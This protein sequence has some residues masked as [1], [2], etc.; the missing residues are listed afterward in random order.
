ML[1]AELNVRLH[2]LLSMF[3]NNADSVSLVK[4]LMLVTLL[5][6]TYNIMHMCSC[7]KYLMYLL[8]HFKETEVSHTWLA[9]PWHSKMYN[10]R[11]RLYWLLSSS[12]RPLSSLALLQFLITRT[13]SA[14]I[15]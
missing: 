2:S 8:I 1:F 3:T 5:L 7:S 4:P 13:Y 9:V 15:V 10:S 14:S 12:E 6:Y 11:F